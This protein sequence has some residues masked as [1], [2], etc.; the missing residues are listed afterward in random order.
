MRQHQEFKEIQGEG[1]GRQKLRQVGGDFPAC[2]RRDND[3]KENK[4]RRNEDLKG[5]GGCR[6]K[7][8]NVDGEVPLC[9]QSFDEGNKGSSSKKN[10]E[11]RVKR[12]QRFAQY[13]E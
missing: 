3:N 5:K 7:H 13:E 6:L 4:M 2:M 12:M 11:E 1:G 8:C 9:M 10:S